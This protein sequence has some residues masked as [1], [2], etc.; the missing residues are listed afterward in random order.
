MKECKF[1]NKCKFNA[2]KCCAYK[3]IKSSQTDKTKEF[4]EQIQNLKNE[5]ER[6]KA[7]NHHLEMKNNE[8]ETKV[9]S[10]ENENVDPQI[11]PGENYSESGADLDLGEIIFNCEIC[12]NKFISEEAL[13]T[14]K[15]ENHKRITILVESIP[16][17]IREVTQVLVPKEKIQSICKNDKEQ[18]FYWCDK[19]DKKF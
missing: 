10:L 4:E 5:V 15:Q 9:N 8:L 3:H 2:R 19:C 16:S 11:V 12:D 13:K 18:T 7:Q 1:S 14:H 17:Q 6:L